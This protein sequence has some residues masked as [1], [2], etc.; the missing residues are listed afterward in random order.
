M[1]P[2]DPLTKI[3][4]SLGLPDEA[5]FRSV[6]DWSKFHGPDKVVF[7]ISDHPWL[8]SAPLDA[9]AATEKAHA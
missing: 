1:S 4:K 8:G 5:S 3:A 9:E 2:Q 6:R 7:D